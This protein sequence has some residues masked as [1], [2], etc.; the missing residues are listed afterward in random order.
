MA[1]LVGQTFDGFKILSKLGDGGM[2]AVYKAR[3][4][5]LNR[6]VAL[7]V[8]SNALAENPEFIGRFK[9][10]ASLAAQFK[11]PHIVQVY[12]AGESNGIHYMAMEFV[13]GTTLLRHIATQGRLNP[14]EAIAIALQIADALKYAWDKS[15][16]IH[17]D[18][19]P[20]NIFLSQ[21]GDV[22]VGDLGLAKI[23][24]SADTELTATGM[25][26]GSPHYMSPE[27]A[28]S[29]KEI[30]FRSDIY[31]LGC[32]LFQLLT[33]RMTHEGKSSMALMVKHVHDPPPDIFEA[34]PDC[35]RKLGLMVSRMIA[36]KRE[37]RPQSYE[38]L[39]AGL[40]EA[41]DGASGEVEIGRPPATA[42]AAPRKR[43]PPRM[44]GGVVAGAIILLLAG[45]AIWSPWKA[46]DAG[47]LVH[48][49]SGEAR[50]LDLGGGVK[51]E[52]VAIPPGEFMMG[53]T[54]EE[55]AWAMAVTSELKEEY[56][57]REG[58]APRKAT[59][60][61][62]FWMG[63]TEVTAGQ[64][65]QFVSATG[66]VTDG[67]KN[68][69]SYGPPATDKPWAPVKG[70]SWRQPKVFALEDSQA[71]TC[72]S[73]NDAEAFCEWLT[74]RERK[75]GRLP[76]RLA[77]RLPTEAEWEYA[78]RA[79]TQTKFWWGESK[80]DGR[81]RLNWAGKKD[82][83]EFV[84]PVDSYGARGRNGFGL[85][86]MLGNVWE[87][88]LDEYDATQAHEECYRGNPNERVLRGGSF[89][90]SP[91]YVRCAY[92]YKDLPARSVLN[93]GFRVAVG[94]VP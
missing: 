83:Q 23:L 43:I 49:K 12:A 80:E 61:Q 62:G 42:A 58:E 59:I 56:V 20:S 88:C 48:P 6:F 74:V 82:G 3:Q 32:T 24:G 78:C 85:A 52:L 90:S 5:S 50:L 41:N 47:S 67:E 22:L 57:K 28:L 87:W 36:R 10:E 73:W 35:P 2:G 37:D 16:M 18:I 39:I 70:M 91:G 89:S 75:A 92:R 77:V 46:G 72:I 15:R 84:A 65:K 63:R 30:D 45:L 64:W 13:E 4:V 54:K 38:D 60:K 1:N 27:Q 79:A 86:D 66:Y 71:V 25:T 51:L 33:G 40:R 21:A 14:Q 7:K 81:D 94:P 31:N 34:L 68:G 69:E 11:H 29:E 44:M 55:Q 17:R 26:V 9:R 8:M 19:K 93:N 76:A 53:S